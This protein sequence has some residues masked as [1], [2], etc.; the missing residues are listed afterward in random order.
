[1]LKIFCTKMTESNLDS[2]LETKS[3]SDHPAHRE[4]GTP[5]DNAV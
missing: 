4:Q 2:D 1:M 5:L 3:E